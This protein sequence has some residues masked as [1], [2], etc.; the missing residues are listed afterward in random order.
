A[1]VVL[2]LDRVVPGVVARERDED[3]LVGGPTP[4][5]RQRPDR[6]HRRRPRHVPVAGDVAQVPVFAPRRGERLQQSPCLPLRVEAHQR[7][8]RLRAS[9]RRRVQVASSS[10]P[11]S[12]TRRPRISS[13]PDDPPYP[14]PMKSVK[15]S[16]G[17]PA[18]RFYSS[19][20]RVVC[21][22]TAP[23]PRR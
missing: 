23:S 19:S 16:P 21:P 12:A 6:R 4:T 13:M 5:S 1:E 17:G 22:R 3:L 14:I 8:S 11:S 15:A 18:G 9:A 7:S 20:E 2:E 10:A